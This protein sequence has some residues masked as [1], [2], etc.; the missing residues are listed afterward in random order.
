[1]I[2]AGTLVAGSERIVTTCG[3]ACTYLG[4]PSIVWNPARSQ[5]GVG[6]TQSTPGGYGAFF[7]E[8]DAN[9]DRVGP[10]LVNCGASVAFGIQ[11]SL[12]WNGTDYQYFWSDKR[13]GN[14]EIYHKLID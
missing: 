1:M 14:W 7:V 2:S 5:Y 4:Y 13:D 6:W 10:S 8:L 9:G 11:P 12:I 3:S